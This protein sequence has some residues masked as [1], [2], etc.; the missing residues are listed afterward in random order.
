MRALLFGLGVLIGLALGWAAYTISGC[1]PWESISAPK[2][3]GTSLAPIR[4]Y[5]SPSPQ[6]ERAII[7]TINTAQRSLHAALYQLTDPE[8]AQALQEAFRKGLEIQIL[9]DDEPSRGSKGCLLRDAGIPVKEFADSGIMHH[10]FAVVDGEKLLTGS[11]NWTTAAQTRNEE[12]LLIIE[13]VE[14]AQAF[15]REFQR[16]WNHRKAQPLS[17]C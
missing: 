13:S 6:P 8:I 7:E 5:F 2:E 11:Y 14:L 16:L 9:L 4:A 10:K 3:I 15:L 12:N 17:K 1:A